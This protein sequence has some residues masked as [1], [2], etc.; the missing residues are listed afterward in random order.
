MSSF[1]QEEKNKM[2]V[3]RMSRRRVG[4]IPVILY[5]N[6]KSNEIVVA[7]TIYFLWSQKNRVALGDP[8]TKLNMQ[9]NNLKPS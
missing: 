9:N 8:E 2:L 4:F 6:D 1:L 7:Q 5:L 3:T